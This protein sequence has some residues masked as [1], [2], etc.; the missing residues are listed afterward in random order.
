MGNKL[1]ALPFVSATLLTI[2]IGG[3]AI[4]AGIAQLQSLGVMSW[5]IWGCEVS[6]SEPW[7][8]TS[9]ALWQRSSRR[10]FVVAVTPTQSPAL[11]GRGWLT[12]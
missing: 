12:C 4:A 7:C 2:G 3:V 9:A 6:T 8:A 11:R 10:W 5:P 1:L